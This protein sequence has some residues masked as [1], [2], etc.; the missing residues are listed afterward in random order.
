[1][2][3]I[4][5]SAHHPGC[6]HLSIDNSGRRDNHIYPWLSSRINRFQ[7]MCCLSR[8]MRDAFFPQITPSKSDNVAA[9]VFQQ[10][11]GIPALYDSKYFAA[12]VVSQCW[13]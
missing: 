9:S 8:Q 12:L 7:Q 6:C 1:M 4:Q 2:F 3:L 13:Q 10:F 11:S 5:T